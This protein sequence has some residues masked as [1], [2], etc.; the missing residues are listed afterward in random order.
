M[1]PVVF[2]FPESIPIIGGANI[3]S[4]GVMLGLAFISGWYLG[5][6]FANR[7][8]FEYK[9]TVTA[10]A[11]VIVFALLGARVAHL[12]TNPASWR[13]TGFFPALFTSKCEGLVAYG[14]FIGGILAVWIYLRFRKK[15]DFWSLADCATPSMALGLGLTRIGCFL[16]GCCHGQPTD[17]GW[18]VVFPEGSQASHAFPD[19]AG[20]SVCVHPTQIYESLL[21]LALFPIA[22]FFLKRRKFTGQAFLLTM[23]LYA[24]G[25]FLLEFIRGDTD[26]GGF[27]SQADPTLSTSQFIGLLLIPFAI[28]IYLYRRKRAPSPPEW[29]SKEQVHE[30]LLE[31]GVIKVKGRK[32]E[33]KPTKTEEPPAKPQRQ[34]PSKKKKK[35]K[36][37]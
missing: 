28:A 15:K 29:L 14:G 5:L 21:G 35:K 1:H 30:R 27:G 20:T 23:P 7:E 22:L 6:H 26:R 13:Y 2:T 31:A 12:I 19:P 25:R 17:V 32:K 8:G 16:A 33:D 24:I 34:G 11:L 3:Y 18:C 37:R 10:F 9:T 4:Y 36:K